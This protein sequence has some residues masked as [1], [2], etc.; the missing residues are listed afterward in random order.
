MQA[1][2]CHDEIGWRNQSRRLIVF[3]TD[4]GY[5]Y[6]GDGKLGGVVKPNDGEC[7]MANHSYTHSVI[8]DYPSVAH[9]NAKVKQTAINLIF[10]VTSGTINVYKELAKYIEGSSSVELKSKSSNVVE[11]IRD[12]YNVRRQKQRNFLS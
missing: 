2:V 3:S 4:A 8:Q 12:Q 11:L 5:H 10:A 1:I 6:A 9:I 7:H